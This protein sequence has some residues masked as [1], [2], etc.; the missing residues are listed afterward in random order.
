MP[1]FKEAGSPGA[2]YTTGSADGT[3]P[4]IFWPNLRDM[5]ALPKY[6]MRTLAAHEGIPGHHTQASLAIEREGGPTF[7]RFAFFTAYIEGW[8]LY[9]EWLVKQ[10]GLY[11]DEPFSELGRLQWE[12]FRMGRLVVDTGIHAKRWTREQAVDW[13]RAHTGVAD[14]EITA[15][16][17]RYIV[18]P[19]QACSYAI[20]MLRI[21]DARSRAE[22]ALGDRFDAA[23]EREFH[24]VVLR[25][26]AVPLTVLDG[27]VDAWLAARA[28]IARPASRQ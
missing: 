11:A 9:A 7:R 8:A 5:N 2:Y 26:G 28:A 3:R 13:M 17:E 16:I 1:A 22:A 10:H 12:L 23:A 20:G 18:M 4:G 25:E 27:Q 21:R 19:G 6:T 24:D 14:S 15:E